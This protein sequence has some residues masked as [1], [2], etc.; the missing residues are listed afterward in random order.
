[1]SNLLCLDSVVRYMSA[2]KP[3]INYL[4]LVLHGD[5]QPIRIALNVEYNTVVA[6][7]AGAVVNR[8]VKGTRRRPLLPFR[9]RT[10]FHERLYLPNVV[11]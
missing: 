7:N 11:H 3:D 9:Y 4:E 2:D 1:M 8:C 6:K 5:N 10:S